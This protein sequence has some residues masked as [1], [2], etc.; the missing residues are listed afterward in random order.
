MAAPRFVRC[1][2][3]VNIDGVPLMGGRNAS[4]GEMIRE[5]VPQG[6]RKEGGRPC[7]TAAWR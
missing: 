7:S 6:I 5:L 3:D 1:F 2:R 4:L